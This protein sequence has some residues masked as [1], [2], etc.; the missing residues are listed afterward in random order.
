MSAT[1]HAVAIVVPG[2][3]A[4]LEFYVGRLGFDLVEDLLVGGLVADDEDGVLHGLLLGA[5][6]GSLRWW[7]ESVTEMTGVAGLDRHVR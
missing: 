2:Y 3:E 5:H 7:G 1:L 4:G 6:G